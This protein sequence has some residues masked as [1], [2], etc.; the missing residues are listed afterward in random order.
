MSDRRPYKSPQLT[1][2][3]PHEV[4]RRFVKATEPKPSPMQRAMAVL[5]KIHD[6]YG[7]DQLERIEQSWFR[8]TRD[9]RRA[10]LGVV[11]AL[12]LELEKIRAVNRC[13][14]RLG[15][16]V[17]G[18]VIEGNW[19]DVEGYASDLTWSTDEPDSAELA[20][21]WAPFVGILRADL[22]RRSTN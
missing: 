1:K 8:Q 15:E 13:G 19:R 2:L 21:L 12:V 16:A 20:K 7:D 6:R 9:E 11:T 22:T 17:I 3:D 14:T 4:I 5:E 10:R 18:A